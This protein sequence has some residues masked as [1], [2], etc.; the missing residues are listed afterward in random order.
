M[1][2]VMIFKRDVWVFDHRNIHTK[3]YRF[4]DRV[5]ASNFIK[6]LPQELLST[7]WG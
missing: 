6:K 4:F 2:N 5:K 3:T 1:I 7:H